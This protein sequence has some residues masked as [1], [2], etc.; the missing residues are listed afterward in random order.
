MVIASSRLSACM[1]STKE[2]ISNNFQFKPRDRS[3][4]R[5]KISSYLKIPSYRGEP[6]QRFLPAQHKIQCGQE[7]AKV[8]GSTLLPLRII[9]YPS[10]HSENVNSKTGS[11]KIRY[12]VALHVGSNIT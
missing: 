3:E 4:K 5:T 10:I 6:V 11:M 8:F 12:L 9:N 2:N 1:W 7:Y